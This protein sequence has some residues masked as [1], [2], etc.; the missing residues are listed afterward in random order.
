MISQQE[1]KHIAKLA[2][3]KLSQKEIFCYQK[4]LADVLRYVNKLR[5]VKVKP[6]F[7]KKVRILEPANIFRQDQINDPV[8]NFEKKSLIKTP[9]RRGRFF[10]VRAIFQKK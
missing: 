10:K 7:K 5:K 2:C 9:Y 3:L 6:S 4:E 8:L 1:V